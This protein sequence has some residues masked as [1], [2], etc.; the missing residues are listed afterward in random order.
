MI[1]SFLIRLFQGLFG[2]F[3]FAYPIAVVGVAF[4]VRPPFAMN[5]AGSALLFLEG[6]LLVLAA[7]LVFGYV[8][9]LLAGA[10][11][12][13]LSYGVEALGVGSG[14]PFG[15]YRYTP[16][17][18]PRLPGGVPL[19]VMCAWVLIVFGTYGCFRLAWRGR[20]LGVAGALLGAVLATLLDL[21]IEPVAAHLENYWQWLVPG[22]LNYYGVPL[23][24][25]VAWFVVAFALLLLIDAILFQ[26]P[27][28]EHQKAA[29]SLAQRLPRW[30]YLTSLLMFGLVDL[31]HG[32]YLAVAFGL[33]AGALA[34]IL[35]TFP[36]RTRPAIAPA[37]R[38][39]Q[40]QALKRDLDGVQQTEE[41]L[42][43]GRRTGDPREA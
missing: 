11:V 8:R 16:V 9:G 19:A 1:R 31:T 4:D 36:D 41:Q 24:N 25:F 13:V 40:D 43:P 26:S 12:V 33:L 30:L 38:V 18:F 10:C 23:T 29:P 17:L 14:F 32:Y 6:I 15:A 37:D 3:C 21:E 42:L 20:R 35:T 28:S 34:L 39:N 2:F 27:L 5:W 7:M 22:S